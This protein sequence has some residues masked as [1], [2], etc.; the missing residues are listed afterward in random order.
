[1]TW[2]SL[3]LPVTGMPQRVPGICFG[4]GGLGAE[5]RGSPGEALVHRLHLP[6]CGG[7]HG[8]SISRPAEGT[9]A[10]PSPSLQR[11]PRRLHLL[12]CRGDQGASVS[13]PVEGTRA[14]PSPSLQRGPQHLDL[15]TCG[16]DHG[17]VMMC[18][19]TSPGAMH[20]PDD[21]QVE[22]RPLISGPPRCLPQACACVAMGP[23]L[24]VCWWCPPRTWCQEG[25]VPGAGVGGLPWGRG[26]SCAWRRTALRAMDRGTNSQ[27]AECGGAGR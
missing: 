2:A 27:G 15:P 18:R 16:G 12:T 19:P 14:S 20:P 25:G 3:G 23:G 24:A 13:R 4:H 22:P 8:P 6:A 1:M 21:T 17:A 7:D 5:C 10:P 11:G 26:R 9:M